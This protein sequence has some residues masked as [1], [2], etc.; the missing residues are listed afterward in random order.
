MFFMNSDGD[1]ILFGGILIIKLY[2]KAQFQQ[3]YS[4]ISR[5]MVIAL[6]K[7][8]CAQPVAYVF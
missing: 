7:N 1:V 2:N 3:S 6:L 4:P 8:I 5:Q